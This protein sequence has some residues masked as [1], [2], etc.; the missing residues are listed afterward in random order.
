M[1]GEFEGAES[2]IVAGAALARRAGWEYGAVSIESM[3]ALLLVY[4]GKMQESVEVHQRISDR[5]RSLGDPDEAEF[6]RILS[7]RPIP[8]EPGDAVEAQRRL[9][10]T[11]LEKARASANVGNEIE[12]LQI[13]ISLD[14]DELGRW[15][16]HLNRLSALIAIHSGPRSRQQNEMFV[17]DEIRAQKR[18]GDVTDKI[19]K[20]ER[21]DSALD[22][23]V[24]L[25]RLLLLAESEFARDR[26][27]SA[28][29]AVDAM[30]KENFQIAATGS[31]CLFA[32]LYAEAGNADRAKL[33]LDACEGEEYDRTARAARADFALLARAR[34]EVMEG[35]SAA[36]WRVIAPRI[37]ELSSFP[38]L[39]R[40]EAESLTR[41][42]RHATGMP[43][44]DRAR[45]RRALRITAAIA[46]RDGAGPSLRLGV[47]LLRWRLCRAEAAGDCGPLLPPWAPEDRFEARKALEATANSAY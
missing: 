9:L 2:R 19:Q 35:D 5:Y 38:T 8:P 47:H 31:A 23:N 18:Y 26:L 41:L 24:K 32:W 12:A 28:I 6:H 44:A 45:L 14:R 46:E 11:V 15:Q 20:A 39:S 43:G 10:E 22:A 3:R 33:L 7:L 37:D 27:D 25:W 34:L 13:L 29:R 40:R 16:R 30:E 4:Q 17:L 42:A 21:D 1:L 36:A